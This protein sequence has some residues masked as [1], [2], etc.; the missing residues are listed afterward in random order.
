[1]PEIVAQSVLIK[2]QEVE[3]IPV[4]TMYFDEHA[5]E[6]GIITRLEAFLDMI[7]WRKSKMGDTND[8]NLSGS[9]RR[10]SQH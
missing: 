7:R 6:A 9:R 5:G 1:M 3:G 10:F 8:Q 4:M 2:V